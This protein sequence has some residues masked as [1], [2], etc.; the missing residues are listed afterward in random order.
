MSWQQV[1]SE[2]SQHWTYFFLGFMT[3]SVIFL[4]FGLGLTVGLIVLK[5]Y[6]RK[7]RSDDV[8]TRKLETERDSALNSTRR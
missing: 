4:S 6:E 3:A 1:L 8:T 7:K 2:Q 5:H